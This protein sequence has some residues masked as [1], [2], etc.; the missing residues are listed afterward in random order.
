M[1]KEIR[2]ATGDGGAFS[3]L[4]QTAELKPK[5]KNSFDIAP[6]G[7]VL[8]VIAHMAGALS[9]RKIRFFGDI[10]ASGSSGWRLRGQLGVTAVQACVI[11]L[12]PVTTRIDTSV[13]CNF[14][15]PVGSDTN[16]ET[17]EFD[18]DDEAEPLGENIDLGQIMIEALVLALPEYPRAKD[19]ELKTTAFAAPGVSP[20]KDADVKPFAALSAL[21]AKLQE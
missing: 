6:E 1:P 10:T 13:S 19:A 21:K 2:S 12:E 4:V 15:H 17:V 5:G 7:E 14:A 20:L 18:G 8:A 3:H 16:D 9:L 11:S